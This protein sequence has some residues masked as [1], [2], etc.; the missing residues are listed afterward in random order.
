M[1]ADA[2]LAGAVLADAVLAGSPKAVLPAL[3]PGQLALH[4]TDAVA[5]RVNGL[6][7]RGD[8]VLD[9][10]HVVLGDHLPAQG[11]PGEMVEPV[12]V[13]GLAGGAK[14]VGALTGSFRLP[15]PSRDRPGILL[16]IVSSEAKVVGELDDGLLCLGHIG[17]VGPDQLIQHPLRVLR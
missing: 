4:L 12:G 3:Q 15:A 13:D 17:R 11:R 5:E 9:D 8:D 2:V 6:M 10:L 14:L 7:L 16:L 1:L